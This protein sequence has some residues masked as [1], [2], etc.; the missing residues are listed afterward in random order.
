MA[1][2]IPERALISGDEAVAL[3]ALNA[4]VLLGTQWATVEAHIDVD[5]VLGLAR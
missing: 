3:A 4:G 2:K 5:A 1:I